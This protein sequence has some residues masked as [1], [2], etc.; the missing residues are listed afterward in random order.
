MKASS[1]QLKTWGKCSLQ[2][3]FQYVDKIDR[4]ETGSAAH[5]GSGVHLGLEHLHNGGTVDEAVKIFQDYFDATEPTYWNRG[6]SRSKCLDIGRKMIRNYADVY[7]WETHVTLGVEKRFMIPFGE[8]TISGI[9]DHIQ[10]DKNYSVLYLD[11]LKT[12][13][14]PN[15]DTLHLDLQFTVYEYASYQPEFW[16]GMESDDPK[17]P[18]KYSGFENGEELYEKF[19]D[20]P[21]KNRWVDLKTTKFIDVGNRTEFDYGRLYRMLEMIQRAIDTETYVPSITA[22]ACS[23]CSYHDLCPVYTDIPETIT[24]ITKKE[25]K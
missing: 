25:D 24:T 6:G 4:W 14:K 15:M 11:D 9:V 1:S 16:I 18:D 17:W 23:W 20:V 2:A 13:A 3:K 22:D 5:M 19:K 8:H 7:K 21:R 10:T 12:G